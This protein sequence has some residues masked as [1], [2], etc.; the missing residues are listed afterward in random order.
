MVE[1]KP[2]QDLVVIVAWRPHGI[3][4][5]LRGVSPFQMNNATVAAIQKRM[6]ADVVERITVVSDNFDRF[7]KGSGRL[8]GFRIPDFAEERFLAAHLTGNQNPTLTVAIPAHC[9]VMQLDPL[10]VASSIY[11]AEACLVC[12]KFFGL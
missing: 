5:K 7:R 8:V 6:V 12:R 9:A 3:A 1:I 10:L 11:G 4:G 2:I